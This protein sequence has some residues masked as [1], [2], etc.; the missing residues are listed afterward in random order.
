MKNE[1]EMVPGETQLK[2]S[3]WP[4]KMRSPMGEGARRGFVPSLTVAE[5]RGLVSRGREKGCD[6][7]VGLTAEFGGG[8]G[9]VKSDP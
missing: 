8:L 9:G 4:F 3:K 2:P 6:F 1:H 7:A 5:R